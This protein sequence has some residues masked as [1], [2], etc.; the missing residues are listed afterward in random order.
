MESDELPVSLK[1]VSFSYRDGQPV[2]HNINLDINKGEIVALC[3]DNGS[4]K[5]TLVKVIL[6]LLE[7]DSGEV[8]IWGNSNVGGRSFEEN[9]IAA[10]FQD[11]VKYPLLLREN[12]GFGKLSKMTSDDELKE[13]LLKADGEEILEKVGGLDVI[14]E[15]ELD[16]CG[17][18]LSGG[19]WQRVALSRIF[20][21]NQDIMIF[22][23]PAASLDPISEKKQFDRIRGELKGK[24]GILISH[25]IGFAS[26]A[27]RIVVLDEGKIIEDG[28]HAELMEIRGKYYSFY[29]A[30]A[31][32]YQS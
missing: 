9:N 31:S 22:D 4:G 10:I 24:T 27:N 30:Q 11:Y 7:P 12:V 8:R 6:G 20:L 1:A 14:L 13:A 32:W 18:E 3:G 23:E 16:D 17:K 29:K 2:L 19:E 21:G 5:S 28:T 25:R 15:R 26:M